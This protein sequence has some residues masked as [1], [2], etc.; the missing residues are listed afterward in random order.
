MVLLLLGAV[1]SHRRA[2]DTGKETAPAL[3]ALAIT[4]AYL[5][6]ALTSWISAGS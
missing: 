5:A 6:V 2:A 3:I 4:T 1:L